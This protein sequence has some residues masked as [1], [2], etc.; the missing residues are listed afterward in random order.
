MKQYIAKFSD[1]VVLK[2]N[3]DSP[4]EA[5]GK[6]VLAFSGDLSDM[7]FDEEILEQRGV[8]HGQS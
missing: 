1:D 6:L 3:A 4:E 8:P 7:T 2:I 5:L